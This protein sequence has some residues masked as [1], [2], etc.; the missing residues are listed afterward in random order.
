MCEMNVGMGLL[1]S[2]SLAFGCA[3]ACLAIRRL[4]RFL[5]R[6]GARGT[7]PNLGRR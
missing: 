2:T 6:L 3:T 1:H 5:E 7:N 4:S